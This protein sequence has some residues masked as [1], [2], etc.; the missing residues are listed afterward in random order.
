MDPLKVIRL[1]PAQA[2]Q[3]LQ[4]VA[5]RDPRGITT[6][7]DMAWFAERGECFAIRGKGSEIVYMLKIENGQAWVQAAQASGSFSFDRV[8]SEVIERQCQGVADS[9]AF[10][11]SRPGLV[12]K[13]RREGYEVTGWILK[14]AIKK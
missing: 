6:A 5:K 8:L 1:T 3:R 11:T 2:L 14:K 13:A 10:Q 7:A 9:V 12:R 4:D